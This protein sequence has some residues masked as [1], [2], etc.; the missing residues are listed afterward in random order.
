MTLPFHALSP[1][2]SRYVHP[3]YLV[4]AAHENL[5]PAAAVV[6]LMSIADE[7]GM[8]KTADRLKPL[9]AAWGHDP[10]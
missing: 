3:D 5:P 6:D 10:A 9:F 8:V 7:R 1:S 2:A 4:E